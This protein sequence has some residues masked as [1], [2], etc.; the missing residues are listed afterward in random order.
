MIREFKKHIPFHLYIN[1]GIYFLTAA[2]LKKE[3]IFDNN[4]KLEI[5]KKQLILAIN[6]FNVTMHAWV[7]LSNHY[8][9]LFSLPRGRELSAFIGFINGSS[10]YQI[11][12]LK[13][14]KGRKVWWN[15]WDKN[16]GGE[17]DFYRRI[18]YIHHN[19]VRHR[20]VKSDADYLFSSY[21]YYENRYGRDFLL[22]IESEYPIIDFTDPNND[23]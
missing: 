22:D 8:H 23:F 12:K 10:S 20:Y 19:P 16:I 14:R 9:L 11:N 17:S 15:Y 7:L 21:N 1:K 3:K 2:S 18:N 5:I 4:S 13:N 6:K